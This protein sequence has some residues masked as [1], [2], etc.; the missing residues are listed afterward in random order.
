MYVRRHTAWKP[1]IG[2]KAIWQI[3][4]LPVGHVGA[5]ERRLR[6]IRQYVPMVAVHTRDEL[7]DTEVTD[8]GATGFATCVVRISDIGVSKS[9]SVAMRKLHIVACRRTPAS[10]LKLTML[11]GEHPLALFSRVGHRKWI[12]QFHVKIL[13]TPEACMYRNLSS[14][15]GI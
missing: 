12:S 9:N 4:L 11:L 2:M 6:S 5:K 1:R 15:V 3:R 14:V 10:C 8:H 13:E 7:P